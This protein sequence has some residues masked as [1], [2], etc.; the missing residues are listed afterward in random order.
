MLIIFQVA[1]CMIFDNISLAKE[2]HMD[3]P[4][5]SVKK[6]S[7]SIEARTQDTLRATSVTVCY[8]PE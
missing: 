1:A 8:K 7:M 5:Q 4:R 3:S 2:S 6:V